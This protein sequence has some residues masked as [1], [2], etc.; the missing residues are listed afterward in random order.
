MN[1]KRVKVKKRKLSIKKLLIFILVLII[2]SLLGYYICSLKISNIYV[3]NNNIITDK[4]VIE[5]SNL[6]SYPSFILTRG[7]KIEKELKKNA[8]IEK[9]KVKKKFFGKMYITIYEYNPLCIEMDSKKLV[10]SSREIVDNTKNIQ[11]LPYLVGDV[12]SI[13]NKFVDKFNLIDRVILEH[14]SIIEYSPNEVD[15]ERFLLYM[16]DGNNV[17]IT[18]TKIEKINKYESIFANL[19]G[20]KGIIYLDSGDYVEVKSA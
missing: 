9:A 16:D 18:L 10:L 15:K 19:N 17:Y 5:L 12:S 14:I 11:N 20:V 13:Y 7:K 4:E 2:I 1:K 3:I 6:S 8:Y